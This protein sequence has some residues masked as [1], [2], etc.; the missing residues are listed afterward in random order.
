MPPVSSPAS[1]PT[2]ADYRDN[3]RTTS[4]CRRCGLL[5]ASSA[6]CFAARLCPLPPLSLDYGAHG[7]KAFDL[8][9]V[10]EFE[11]PHFVKITARALIPPQALKLVCLSWRKPPQHA[12]TSRSGDLSYPHCSLACPPLRSPASPA[13]TARNGGRRTQEKS[14]GH[15]TSISDPLVTGIL[16]GAGYRDGL[17]RRLCRRSRGHRMRKRI[18][19]PP[20][21]GSSP[22]AGTADSSCG[23]GCGSAD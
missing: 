15:I 14:M 4:A 10:R 16:T 19:S 7:L 2:R 13:A 11:E 21:P 22:P 1:P 3:A 20:H 6:G 23:A 12:A 9:L 17:V 8:V 18:V 5:V